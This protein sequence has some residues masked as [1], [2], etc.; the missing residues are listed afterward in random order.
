MKGEHVKDAAQDGG[1]KVL[2]LPIAI[3]QLRWAGSRGASSSTPGCV[4]ARPPVRDDDDT[5]DP[6]PHHHHHRRS[7]SR[8]QHVKNAAQGDV[9]GVAEDVAQDLAFGA[10]SARALIA[11]PPPPPPPPSLCSLR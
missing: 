2:I 1:V 10:R 4:H 11:T 7:S 6:L 5:L 8:R 3:F 9:E